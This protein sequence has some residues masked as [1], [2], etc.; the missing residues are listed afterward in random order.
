[1]SKGVFHEVAE[2]IKAGFENIIS[3]VV[4]CVK[5]PFSGEERGDDSGYWA[6]VGGIPSLLLALLFYP[7]ILTGVSLAVL[8]SLLATILLVI[9]ATIALPIAAVIDLVLKVDLS[10]PNINN[11][12]FKLIDEISR[13]QTSADHPA[14]KTKHL[15]NK[16]D[17]KVILDKIKDNLDIYKD[18]SDI[19][20]KDLLKKILNLHPQ[21]KRF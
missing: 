7:L 17:T 2:I 6:I 19:S 9:A 21:K 18:K 14:E 3:F 15:H 8:A 1:M 11:E 5:F 10:A 20:V 12:I 13:V 4:K 16:H